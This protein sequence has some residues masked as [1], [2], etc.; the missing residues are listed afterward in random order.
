M[1]VAVRD[2]AMRLAAVLLCNTMVKPMP[3]KSAIKRL[4]RWLASHL[5]MGVP[6]PRSRLVD[7]MIEPHSNKAMEPAICISKN[8]P[9]MLFHFLVCKAGQFNLYQ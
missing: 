7:M 5:R 9:C 8:V 3:A 4:R 2:V 1:P 6:K